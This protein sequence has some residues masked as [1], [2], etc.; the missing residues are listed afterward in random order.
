MA[1]LDSFFFN[2]CLQLTELL[3]NMHLNLFHWLGNSCLD[4]SILTLSAKGNDGDG[5]YCIELL[6]CFDLGL[7]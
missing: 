5:Y 1:E 2:M 7:A 3:T 4:G 6:E